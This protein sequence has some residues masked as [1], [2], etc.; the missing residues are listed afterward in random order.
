MEQPMM[1]MDQQMYIQQQQQQQ[2]QM[3]MQMQMEQQRYEEQQ[4]FAE[5]QMYMERMRQEQ[6]MEQ[7]RQRQQVMHS[8]M[9]QMFPAPPASAPC[10]AWQDPYATGFGP[11]PSSSPAGAPLYHP[12][13][14]P[15]AS[16]PPT[17][18]TGY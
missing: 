15:L 5:Q 12:S 1:P 16:G 3:Q 4:R 9:H 6:H 13:G 14:S 17:S 18:F 10:G 8:Q 2:M 7:M 11:T